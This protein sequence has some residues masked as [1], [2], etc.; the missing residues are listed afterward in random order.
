MPCCE[1]KMAVH[2]ACNKSMQAVHWYDIT[3]QGSLTV[4]LPCDVQAL[5]QYTS[6]HCHGLHY[7]RWHTYMAAY[8]FPSSGTVMLDSHTHQW[9][10]WCTNCWMV[11]QT[12]TWCI[13][14]LLLHISSKLCQCPLLLLPQFVTI[15]LA[16]DEY[17]YPHLWMCS[18]KLIYW[19]TSHM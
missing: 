7:R 19:Q 12:K 11:A 18:M 15:G 3:D 10:L 14:F 17:V 16:K 5:I 2:A 13:V 4:C 9:V 6:L 8:T 1:Y